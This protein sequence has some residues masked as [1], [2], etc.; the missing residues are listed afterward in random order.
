ML[1]RQ[2][3]IR[4]IM[5]CRIAYR[6]V[7]SHRSERGVTALDIIECGAVLWRRRLR[8][9]NIQ[10]RNMQAMERTQLER[11]EGVI[12]RHSRSADLRRVR[13]LFFCM[14][15]RTKGKVT[16]EDDSW[17]DREKIGA[18]EWLKELLSPFKPHNG[19]PGVQGGSKSKRRENWAPNKSRVRLNGRP[20]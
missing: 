2:S 3:Y 10:A 17:F 9:S 19:Y 14:L 4:V 16:I 12:V 20:A 13:E 18:H 1:C 11:L 8:F 15:S 6:F 7:G 5:R